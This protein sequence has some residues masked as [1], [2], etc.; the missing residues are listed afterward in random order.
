MAERIA[1]N[2]PLSVQYAKELIYRSL[3]L[4]DE[5]LH[6]LTQDLYRGLLES[7]DAKEGPRAFVEK[8]QPQ[9]LGR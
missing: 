2:A 1:D 4:D 3:D 9:W 6:Q 7:E 8:R 5:R